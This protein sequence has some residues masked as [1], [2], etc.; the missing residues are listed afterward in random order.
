[1]SLFLKLVL[2]HLLG[3][4]TLQTNRIFYIKIKYKW[5]TLLHSSIVGLASLVFSFAYLGNLDVVVSII[6]LT[7]FHALQDRAKIGYNADVAKDNIWTFLLDQVVH[8]GAIGL[9]CFIARN[10]KPN[11]VLQ[12]AWLNAYY[13]NDKLFLILIWLVIVS[14][15]GVIFLEYLKKDFAGAQ[16]HIK[17]PGLRLKYISMLERVLI[18]MAVYMGGW[19]WLFVPAAFVPSTILC[20]RGR[21]IPIDL[22]SSWSFALLAGLLMKATV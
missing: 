8:V 12:P 7:M 21:M 9:V 18:A 17:I 20:Y 2:G 10:A 15:S 16:H 14:Y 4:F 13:N 6:I 3:D 5:G 11:I 19:Y 1:M 22:V